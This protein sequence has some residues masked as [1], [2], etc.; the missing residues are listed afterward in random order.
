[1]THDRVNNLLLPSNAG[2]DFATDDGDVTGTVV[3]YRGDVASRS[4]AGFLFAGRESGPY[5]N[6]VFGPDVM[7]GF[8]PSDTVRVQYLRSDT[9]YPSAIVADYGQPEGAFGGERAVGHVRPLLALLVLVGVGTRT[10]TR[11][12]APT[13]GSS[14][15]WTCARASGFVQRRFWGT[16][17]G[18]VHD[19]RRRGRG[20]A[21]QRT[22]TAS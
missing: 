12:S 18:L 1:M 8:T 13:A 9:A 14:R 21:R 22:T 10:V 5:H 15:A 16:V 19:V 3:R 4:T 2:S 20:V 7:L 17:Q 11:T 6:R